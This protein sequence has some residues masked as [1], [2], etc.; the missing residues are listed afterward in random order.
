MRRGQCATVLKL[1]ELSE[2]DRREVEKFM[3]F[4]RVESARRKGADLNACALLEAAIYPDHVGRGESG[5]DA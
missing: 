3:Q 5:G 4:L 2:G 1:D